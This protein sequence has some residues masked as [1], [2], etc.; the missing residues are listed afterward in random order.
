MGFIK[1]KVRM[2][3][4]VC[5]DV[6]QSAKCS[7]YDNISMY[8]SVICMWVY[9]I[10]DVGRWLAG[11]LDDPGVDHWPQLINVCAIHTITLQ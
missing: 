11:L 1:I 5:F 4:K 9:H 10:S 3:H 2:I 6:Y 7:T 8:T